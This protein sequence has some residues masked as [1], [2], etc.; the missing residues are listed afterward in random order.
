[1]SGLMYSMY[2]HGVYRCMDRH[3][4]D[5]ISIKTSEN[6]EQFASLVKKERN[7]RKRKGV[8]ISRAGVTQSRQ[9]TPK[10]PRWINERKKNMLMLG[11]TVNSRLIIMCNLVLLVAALWPLHSYVGDLQGYNV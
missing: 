11:G 7:R 3:S 9:L 6:P 5:Q 2:G 8:Y 10:Q 1:M 4:M